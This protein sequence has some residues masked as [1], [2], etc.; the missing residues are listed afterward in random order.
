MTAARAQLPGAEEGGELVGVQPGRVG[1]RAGSSLGVKA[2]PVGRHS[3]PMIA[4]TTMNPSRC[5]EALREGRLDRQRRGHDI[6]AE[7]VLELDRLG[8]RRDRVGV[9]LGQLGV[10]IEDVVELAFEPGELGVGQ[11]EAGEMGDMGDVVAGEGGHGPMIA[12]TIGPWPRSTPSARCGP[13]T[14]TRP[15]R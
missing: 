14:S 13:T 4:G 15:P 8:G 1:H 9:E 3:P 6:V 7:D 5:S 2:G 12:A 10:L 11:P